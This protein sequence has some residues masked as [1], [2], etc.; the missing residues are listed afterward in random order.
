MRQKQKT[1]R[2][3]GAVTVSKTPTQPGYQRILMRF[4]LVTKEMQIPEVWEIWTR[5]AS[6][7]INRKTKTRRSKLTLTRFAQTE[8]ALA[9][10]NEAE[11]AALNQKIYGPRS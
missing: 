1:D 5:V 10:M 6:A 8:A 3:R 4:G 7:V 9:S 2:T 11:L